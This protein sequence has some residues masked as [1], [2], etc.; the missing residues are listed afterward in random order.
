MSAKKASLC[1]VFL[2]SCSPGG[3]GF[4]SIHGLILAVAKTILFEFV[5][6][7]Y[8]DYLLERAKLTQSEVH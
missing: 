1:G 7:F 8:G 5:L 3:R 4:W 2:Q 6:C